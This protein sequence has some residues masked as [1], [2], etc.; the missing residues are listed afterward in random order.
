MILCFGEYDVG[1]GVN[2]LERR[3]WRKTGDNPFFTVGGFTYLDFEL[4]VRF[5]GISHELLDVDSEKREQLFNKRNQRLALVIGN[6]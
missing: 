6:L 1:G 3:T 4:V 5:V 2:R